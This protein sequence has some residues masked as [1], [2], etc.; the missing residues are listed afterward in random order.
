MT[1]GIG[2]RGAQSRRL[3]SRCGTEDLRRS[4]GELGGGRRVISARHRI[5]DD[6]L[7]VD[8]RETDFAGA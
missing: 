6:L 7:R 3:E 1:Y 2:L 4:A 8:D 5:D